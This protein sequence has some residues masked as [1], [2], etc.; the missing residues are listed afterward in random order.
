MDEIDQETEEQ[1]ACNL[2]LIREL[3]QVKEQLEA[4]K[5]REEKLRRLALEEEVQKD[6]MQTNLIIQAKKEAQ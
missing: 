6:I 5:K 2:E 4:K 3:E 1:Y